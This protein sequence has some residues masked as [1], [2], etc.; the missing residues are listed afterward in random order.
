MY[1]ILILFQAKTILHSRQKELP[2]RQK[3]LNSIIGLKASGL[4]LQSTDSF[5][6]A[7]FGRSTVIFMFIGEV[8]FL[9]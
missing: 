1:I 2:Q 8:T 6:F 9:H 3:I 5:I 7:I 4:L